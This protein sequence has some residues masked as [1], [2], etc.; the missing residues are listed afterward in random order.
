MS[1]TVCFMDRDHVLDVAATLLRGRTADSEEAVSRFL[2]PEPVDADGLFDLEPALTG[3]RVVAPDGAYGSAVR[4]PGET[5]VLVVRRSVVSAETMRRLPHLRHVV[6][7]GERMD[8]IDATYAEQHGIGLTFVA[9]PSLES[10]A[11]HTLLLML[12]CRRRLVELDRLVRASTVADAPG[13]APVAY[14]WA[15]RTVLPSLHGATVGLVGMGE[16][17]VLVAQRLHAFGAEVLYTSR[18][19]EVAADR[20][21]VG[22]RRVPLEDLLGRSDVVSL[23]VPG[24]AEN[25]H[26]AGGA[27]FAAMRPGSVFV[28]VA[29]GNLVD[30]TALAGALASGRIAAAGLDVHAHE[31]RLQSDVLLDHPQVLLTPHIAGGLRSAVIGEISSVLAGVR[32]GLEPRST[33]NAS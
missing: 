26:L 33:R 27:F 15:G 10:T 29:R 12:A 25:R 13:A 23:H 22:A 2:A 31:P 4:P 19:P 24:T 1:P 21:G 16:V 14:N 6:K 11:E 3:V 32:A 17:G 9:R 18:A 30:E 8:T 28:N 20:Q 7:L 5:H